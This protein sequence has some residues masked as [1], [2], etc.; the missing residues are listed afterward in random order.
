MA[1]KADASVIPIE[2]ARKS[3]P[4][5]Y[6][7]LVAGRAYLIRTVTF[8]Y[9]GMLERITPTELVLSQA[10]WVAE[11]GRY[12]QFLLNG[13]GDGAVEVEPCPDECIVMRGG[14]VDAVPW[15]HPL[16]RETR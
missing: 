3:D 11:T 5:A 7:G 16:P 13:N 6:P 1:K 10:S 2:T 4:D 12:H 15:A 14:V 8:T 9:L